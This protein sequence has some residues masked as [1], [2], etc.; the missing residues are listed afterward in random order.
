VTP[1]PVEPPTAPEPDAQRVDQ[2]EAPAGAPPRW[3]VFAIGAGA[4]AVTAGILAVVG[5][6]GLPSWA[7]VALSVAIT[8]ASSL[9]TNALIGPVSQRVGSLWV[10]IAVLL[11]VI[12]GTFVYLAFP[13]GPSFVNYVPNR[14]VVLSGVAGA[15]PRTEYDAPVFAPGEEDSSDCYVIYH[16]RVWLA[17]QTSTSY[18]LGWAPLADFHLAPDAQ[19]ALPPN[20]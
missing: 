13:A 1:K 6:A 12:I 16:G 3:T 2:R 14:E 17:F 8:A 7:I 15:S 10:T 4:G 19:A 18:G 11:A 20:C 9:A 5:V